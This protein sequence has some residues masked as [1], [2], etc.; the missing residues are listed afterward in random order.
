M[1]Y[2]LIQITCRGIARFDRR[3]R[4]AAEYQVAIGRQ[5]EVAAFLVRVVT[6]EAFLLQDRF[7]MFVKGNLR[8]R[9]FL[10]IC[11]CQQQ[12]NDERWK[13][14]DGNGHGGHGVNQMNSLSW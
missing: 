7:D 6:G 14:T 8:R 13:Q 12:E 10:G 2:Q 4:R 11:R 9:L 3:A 5:I 1:R